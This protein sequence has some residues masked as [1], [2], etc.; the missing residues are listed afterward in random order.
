MLSRTVVEKD[1]LQRNESDY[2]C[3]DILLFDEKLAF[4]FVF[5]IFCFIFLIAF[6]GIVSN[7]CNVVIFYKHG[8]KDTVNISLFVLAISDLCS[9][10]PLIWTG[11]LAEPR[12]LP[13]DVPFNGMDVQFLAGSW[14]HTCF[15]RLTSWITTYVMFE[16]CLSIASPFQVKMFLTPRRVLCIHAVIQVL[17]V[18]GVVPTYCIYSLG[19]SYDPVYNKSLLSLQQTDNALEIANVTS[20][21]NSFVST[22]CSFVATA[23]CTSVII[24]KLNQKT[25]WRISTTSV[26][27]VNCALNTITRKDRKAIKMVVIVSLV[28]LVTV[29]PSVILII[30]T[31]ANED[32][33]MY[34][35]LRNIFYVAYSFTFLLEAVNSSF[36]I[37][38]YY[39]MNGRYRKTF[40]ELFSIFCN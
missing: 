14:P 7:I 26:A 15:A 13:Y 30:I 32:F 21:L 25:Q 20:V 19:W 23:M 36:N 39:T 35:R 8:F 17:I 37:I 33:N 9:I 12:F 28:F 10:L 24:I 6:V 11:V 34:G 3:C 29:S 40:K 5:A 2:S 31:M 1:I 38:I 16:R 22:L 27:I 18:A 4:N